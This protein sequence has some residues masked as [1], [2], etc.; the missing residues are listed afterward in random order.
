MSVGKDMSKLETLME[1]EG[2]DSLDEMMVIASD[3]VN[4]GICMNDGC[5]YTT[6]VEPDCLDGYCEY[7]GTRSVTGATMLLLSCC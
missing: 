6:A 3:S 5:S 7:C 2:I 1:N 4:P